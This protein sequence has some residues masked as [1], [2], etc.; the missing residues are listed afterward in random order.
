MTY[1]I[2]EGDALDRLRELSDESVHCCVTSPPYWG[3]RDYGVEPSIWGG[4]IYMRPRLGCD[5]AR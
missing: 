1:R 2:I 4:G 5:A 3:L